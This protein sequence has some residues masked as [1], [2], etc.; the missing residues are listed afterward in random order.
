MWNQIS[1]LQYVGTFLTNG[2][3]VEQNEI[4]IQMKGVTL[5][6]KNPKPKLLQL[7]IHYT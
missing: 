1:P 3:K 7:F 4:K 6:Q 5:L 2:S